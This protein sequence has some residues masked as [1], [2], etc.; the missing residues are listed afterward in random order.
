MLTLVQRFHTSIQKKHRWMKECWSYELLDVNMIFGGYSFLMYFPS[1]FSVSRVLIICAFILAI[2]ICW[3]C[4]M[5]SQ[6]I[7]TEQE[8]KRTL[9]ME[10]K[11][12]NHT[13]LRPAFPSPMQHQSISV[14]VCKVNKNYV[15]I[16]RLLICNVTRKTRSSILNM[17]KRQ[18]ED[19]AKTNKSLKRGAL[20]SQWHNP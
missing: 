4:F 2:S 16:T 5:H 19:H 1:H 9:E 15:K 3:L 8:A 10:K 12:V 18:M 11:M 20:Q 14:Q 6:V 13:F 7:A 17:D